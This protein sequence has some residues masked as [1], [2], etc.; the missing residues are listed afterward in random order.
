MSSG[1]IVV[2]MGTLVAAA[3]LLLARRFMNV[4]PEDLARKPD[5]KGR[6]AD[7]FHL[8]GRMMAAVGILVFILCVAIGFGLIPT[9]LDPA[10]FGGGS[11]Q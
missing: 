10:S 9:G 6:T 1:W 5:P 3:D 2:L 4:T 11:G 7:Q 8:A